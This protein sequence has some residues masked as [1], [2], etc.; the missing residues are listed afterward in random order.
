VMLV[1]DLMLVQDLRDLLY[2]MGVRSGTGDDGNGYGHG[3]AFLS[4]T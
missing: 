1:R 3:D 4:D 2:D